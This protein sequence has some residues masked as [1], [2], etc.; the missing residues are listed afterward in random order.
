MPTYELSGLR[1][2]DPCHNSA[3]PNHEVKDAGIIKKG[4]CEAHLLDQL[5]DEEV[6]RKAVGAPAIPKTMRPGGNQA[7]RNEIT[8]SATTTRPKETYK[9]N[10]HMTTKQFIE[11]DM[12]QRSDREKI[13]WEPDQLEQQK[14]IVAEQMAKQNKCM[15]M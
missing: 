12:A 7:I 6:L 11:A 4:L 14:R 5:R 13:Y 10:T 3:A 9:P 8:K 1:C 2:F 15:V